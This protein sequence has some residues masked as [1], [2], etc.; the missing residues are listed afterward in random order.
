MK[1]TTNNYSL[2]DTIV[3]LSSPYAKSAIAVIRMSGKEAINI[4]KAISVSTKSQKQIESFTSHK[5]YYVEIKDQETIVDDAVILVMKRPNT[6]TTEDVVEIYSHGSIPIIE[7]I[8]ALI[9]KH[10]A[11]LASAGEFTYRAYINGRLD[12]SEATAIH[13]LID[14]NN[15]LE[16]EASIYK[17]KGRLKT[18]V[19]DIRNA[20]TDVLIQIEGSLDFPE[21]DDIEFSYGDITGA[22]KKLLEKIEY[23]IDASNTVR[24]FINGVRI[25]IVGKTNVGKSSIFNMLLD[26]ERAIV[27]D[28]AGT[29]RDSLHECI[30][31]DS[32]P[33][34]IMDTAGFHESSSDKIEQLGIERSTKCIHEADFVIA[35]FD[36]NSKMT[37]DD[38]ATLEILKTVKNKTLI[39]VLNKTDLEQNNDYDFAANFPE[40]CDSVKPVLLSVKNK[41]GKAELVD[42]IKSTTSQSDIEIFKKET[43]INMTEKEYLLKSIDVIHNCLAKIDANE[44][45]DI[46]AE[47]ARLVL[48]LINNISHPLVTDDIINEIFS[49]FC[50]G[51]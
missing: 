34:Y 28:I 22:F 35:V 1:N 2:D 39:F 44:S 36:Y 30:Y 50:I 31:I 20:L 26:S 41:S 9:I 10:G 14:A 45:L 18:E 16:A 48:A 32:I 19:D 12:I 51:K 11:R 7:K 13:D 25:A 17:M 46:V 33:Y 47:E 42:R 40:N 23:I 27:S 5:A 29:T 6:Y 3:A 15:Y 38:N 4:A 8:I 24:K 21:D 49:R 37:D 43:Y